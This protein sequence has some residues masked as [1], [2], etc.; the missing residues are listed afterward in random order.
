MVRGSVTCPHA[1]PTHRYMG[2][3]LLEFLPL[4]DRSCTDESTGGGYLG[5]GCHQ[6]STSA[7]RG[8]DG[9]KLLER[10]VTR[11]EWPE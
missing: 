10:V 8:S 5:R 3:R 9:N 4:V 6:K 1:P 7:M 2:A 11:L